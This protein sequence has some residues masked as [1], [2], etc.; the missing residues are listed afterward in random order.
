M[1]LAGR[2]LYHHVLH[3][4]LPV[5]VQVLPTVPRIGVRRRLYGEKDGLGRDSQAFGA[6]CRGSANAGL[7]PVQI[8]GRLRAD[9]GGSGS[10]IC[11]IA[12]NT[13]SRHVDG[14][15]F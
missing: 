3:A 10:L 13:E 14:P 9:V 5:I 2:Y 6:S 8:A 12:F 11:V 7:F 1:S 4:M 15:R